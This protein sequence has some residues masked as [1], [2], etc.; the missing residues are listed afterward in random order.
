MTR[1]E[2]ES[3]LA[4]CVGLCAVMMIVSLARIRAR[5]ASA[6]LQA[7]GFLAMGAGLW[8]VR[9]RA[10]NVLIVPVFA[11]VAVCLIGDVAYRAGRRGRE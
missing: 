3:F 4:A 7:G 5:G 1:D 2:F 11:L 6:W 8:L 10:E 9:Q